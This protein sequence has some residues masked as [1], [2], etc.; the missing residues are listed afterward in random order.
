MNPDSPE[1][2]TFRNIR[3]LIWLYF[4]LLLIEGALRK[5]MLP[6]LS[7]PL[8]IIRDPVLLLAYI[9]AWRA[10]VFPRNRWV[11]ALAI[12]GFLSLVLSVIPLWPYPLTRILFI[13]GYG[14]HANF[15]HLPLIFLMPAMLRREDVKKIGWWMLVLVVPMSLLMVAQFQEGPESILN[16]T[17]SG[18]GEMITAGSGKVRTSGTFSF[19]IGVVSYYAL[20][21]AFLIWAALKRG[22]YRNWLLIASGSALVIGIVVSGSRSVVAA[23]ALVIASLL[24]VLILR[25][26]A[27]N[28][29]GQ[30]LVITV[31]LGFILTKIPIFKEGLEVLTTRFFDVAEAT[32]QSIT[33]GMF[34]RIMEGFTNGIFILGKAPFLGFGLGI[35][36]NAAA[37]FLTGE[38]AFLLSEEEWSRIFL[39][40]GPVLGLAYVIWRCGLAFQIGFLCLKS[41]RGGNILPLLLFSSSFLPLINGQF[42]Q[43]TVLGFTVFVTGLALAARDETEEEM[44]PGA[45]PKKSGLTTKRVV[46]RRSPYADRLHGPVVRRD[47]NNGSV[48]R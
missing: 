41:V 20:A 48:D 30:A 26:R 17:A 35:G 19:I 33:A 43:P 6:K 8:L 44:L 7:T 5:W 25:P 12:I 18:E 24:V 46:R 32:E 16:R 11:L 23:C 34:S 31:G 21:T 10:G 42:G 29:L 13:S 3:Q 36:T 9:L 45:A 1:N 47:Q 27:V 39:E 38:T 37:K 22:V 2:K 28:R 14:F 4:W 40:S 15:L